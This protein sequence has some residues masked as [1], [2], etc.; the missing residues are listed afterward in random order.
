MQY[1]ETS[2][3]LRSEWEAS[4]SDL[5][6]KG[7]FTVGR[8]H[9]TNYF[10]VQYMKLLHGI[11]IPDSWVSS[12][13]TNISDTDTRKVMYMECCDM[14]SK[15]IMNEI[16]KLVKSPYVGVKIYRSGKYVTK[17]EFTEE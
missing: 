15:N 10:I 9:L 6:F 16:R 17:I 12:C 3:V 7:K 2:I 4:I 1:S 14:L 8:F 11:E 5:M 13:F